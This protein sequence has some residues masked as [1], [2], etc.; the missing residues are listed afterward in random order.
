MVWPWACAWQWHARAR[1]NATRMRVA[2]NRA[3]ILLA[4][5]RPG[6]LK[7]NGDLYSYKILPSSIAMCDTDYWCWSLH[8]ILHAEWW[9]FNNVGDMYDL[10]LVVG[11]IVW[12]LLLQAPVLILFGQV[13]SVMILY[14]VG[15][16]SFWGKSGIFWAIHPIFWG[17]SKIFGTHISEKTWTVNRSSCL[18]LFQKVM[19][20]KCQ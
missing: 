3:G 18:M 13:N 12:I 20:Q 16:C 6:Q 7:R 9:L 10:A 2:T 15:A 14:K 19:P 11:N 17:E 8:F 5:M 4:I 1:G